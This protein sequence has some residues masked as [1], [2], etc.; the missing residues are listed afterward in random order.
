MSP[1]ARIP[2]SVSLNAMLAPPEEALPWIIGVPAALQVSPPSRVASTRARAAAPVAIQP[3]R[4]PATAVQVP[5]AAKA[6][7]PSCA[8]GRRSPISVQVVPSSVRRTGNQPPTASLMVKPRR[9]SQN[10]KQS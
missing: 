5:L 2:L 7:S 1:P 4:S 9:E 8:A 10:A 6:P 3:W